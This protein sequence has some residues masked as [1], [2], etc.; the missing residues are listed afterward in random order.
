MD[1]Q[2]SEA[3]AK[4]QADDTELIRKLR[5]VIRE[6]ADHLG[7]CKGNDGGGVCSCGFS[8]VYAELVKGA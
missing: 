3:I 1:W 8:D 5:Q 7:D 2:E 6:Y 4:M